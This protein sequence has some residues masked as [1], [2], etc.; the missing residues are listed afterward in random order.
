MVT[1]C[2]HALNKIGLVIDK[3][4]K[5]LGKKEVEIYFVNW[6]QGKASAQHLRSDLKF[7]SRVK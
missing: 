2:R 6:A 3:R 7:V 1:E 5:T 4:K